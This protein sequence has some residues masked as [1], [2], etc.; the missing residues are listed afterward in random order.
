MIIEHFKGCM[1]CKAYTDVEA[2]LAQHTAQGTNE[3]II[4]GEEPFPY[5]VVLK[6]NNYAYVHYYNEEDHPGFRSIGNEY[7]L[8]S[9]GDHVFY[10][11]TD[12][13][14]VWIE[15][16]SIVP[17]TIAELAVKQFYER[18]EM[19]ACIDWDEL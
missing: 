2:V 16:V 19:P 13:E 15:N 8:D 7:D 6:N 14:V 4:R 17:F 9:S 11:N 10:T 12:Q 1:T 3:F 18:M 5:M